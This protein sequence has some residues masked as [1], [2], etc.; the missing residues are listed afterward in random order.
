MNQSV[1]AIMKNKILPT[2]ITRA[3][4]GALAIF[5]VAASSA[6]AQSDVQVINLRAGWNAVWLEVDP[7][8]ADGSVKTPETVFSGTSVTRVF[9]PR[10]VSGTAE[11]FGQTATNQVSSTY[12]Q[13]G[14]TEYNPSSPVADVDRL[15]A[16][17]GYRPYLMFSTQAGAIVIEGRARFYRPTWTPDRFN[18]IGF[19]IDT[20]NPPTFQQFFGPSGD[21]H[22]LTG[23]NSPYALQADGTWREVLPGE[24]MTS[25]E[26][27]WV[28]SSGPS[29]YM[30]PVSVDFDGAM[31]G[32]LDF[33][34][35]ADAVSVGEI[36][37][38]RTSLDL[39]M[40]VFANSGDTDVTPRV[41]LVNNLSAPPEEL[42]DDLVLYEVNPV[43]NRLAYVKSGRLPL[44][45]GDEIAMRD[46][47]LIASDR[48]AYL[49]LG[50]ERD[51][52]IGP[53]SRV[54]LYRL[55]PG[56]GGAFYLPISALRNELQI[57]GTLPPP[58]VQLTGLWVGE[59]TVDEVTS[60][61]PEGSPIQ[62]SAGSSTF[63]V[64]LHVDTGG[65]VRLLSQATLMQTRTADP[66]VIPDPVIVLDPAKIPFFEGIQ[67]RDGKL[68]G[69]RIQ[70]VTY[71]MPRKFDAVSQSNL[72]Q[73]SF[74]GLAPGATD[75]DI[76]NYVLGR[77]LRPV[78]LAEV[79]HL[80][81]PLEGSL[82]AGQTVETDPDNPL[83]LDPFHRSNPFRHVYH[84]SHGAAANHIERRMTFDFDDTNPFSGLLRG[85]FSETVSRLIKA[86][87]EY[88]GRFKLQRVSDVQ[89]LEQ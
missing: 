2:A 18:L 47:E 38:E 66:E 25:G 82:G 15:T 84:Q 29:R 3:V 45:P 53:V 40:V 31:I 20:V 67:E 60:I 5:I 8:N 73:N 13:E 77:N 37:S 52:S 58:G 21:R 62:P 51:W 69:L 26:A 41:T 74:T 50:A 76:L 14:W 78:D 32:R 42:P 4:C 55:F 56:G 6:L 11:F 59:V 86:D 89:E 10:E 43:S 9:S 22:P 44:T 87:L 71:D 79:Y 68:V 48:A 35:P 12:N 75:E 19:G 64:M 36:E 1:K 39:E 16:V 33:S 65:V 7:V 72:V 46:G 81:W 24:S 49:T 88:R 85:T 30:G 23:D 57:S 70:A 80:S 27:Y 28:F 83:T 34:G 61:E 17:S 63:R 54:K